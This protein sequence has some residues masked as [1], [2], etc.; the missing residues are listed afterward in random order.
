MFT[1]IK[2][3]KVFQL[4]LY[5]EYINLNDFEINIRTKV[6]NDGHVTIS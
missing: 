1:M 2:I 4:L 6:L 5:S 3:N